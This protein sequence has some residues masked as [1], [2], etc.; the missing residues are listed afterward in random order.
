MVEGLQVV[1]R[2]LRHLNERGYT[3]I[4]AN[5]LWA[6]LTLPLVTAPAAWAG[7]VKVSYTALSQ[8][9]AEISLFW[10][11]FR[12]NFRRGLVMFVLN[13]IIIV[14]NVSN[15]TAYSQQTGVEVAFARMVWILALAVWFALQLYLWPLLYE[16]KEPKL[17]G[18][19]RNALVMIYLNPLFTLS[20]LLCALVIAFLS[21]VF[22]AAW[23]L[24]S[25]SALAAIGTSAVFNRLE[26]AGLRQRP[27][28]S[29]AEVL[30][31]SE[32]E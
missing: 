7:L 21:T 15:L 23:V 19:M 25:G 22:M 32:W 30:S 31:A 20:V 12:Q 24:I 6:L 5:V 29:E 28:K 27:V 17:L 16:M 8:P 14:V 10:E 2:G 26:A 11:G 13:V 1:W 18:A 4:W 9:T 3:Y